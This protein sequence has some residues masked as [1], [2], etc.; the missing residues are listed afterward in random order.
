[1]AKLNCR[2][3]GRI[4][5]DCLS[6]HGYRLITTEGVEPLFQVRFGKMQYEWLCRDCFAFLIHNA[7]W[8]PS[9]DVQRSLID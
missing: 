3:C 5:E 6:D 2:C 4:G 8:H 1:M 7:F 9:L